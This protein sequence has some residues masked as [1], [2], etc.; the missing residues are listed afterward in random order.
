MKIYIVM[1]RFKQL[2]DFTSVR[3]S[4]ECYE[5]EEQA[6]EFCKSRLNKEELEK[7]ERLLKKRMINKYEFDSKDYEYKIEI[8]KVV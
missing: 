4:Q 3:V 6:I 1:S 2:T 8:L 5:T 7:H